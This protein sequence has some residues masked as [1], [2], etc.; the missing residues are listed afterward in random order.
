[1]LL[2][3]LAS[4]IRTSSGRLERNI[5]RFL[6][7]GVA[8][9]ALSTYSRGGFL[10]VAGLVLQ[11]VL[12]SRHRLRT[13][14]AATVVGLITLSVLPPEF[15]ERMST[16]QST[17][18]GEYLDESTAGRLHYWEVG[19]AM[20]NDRPLVGVGQNA[21]NAAYNSYDSS[22]GLYG[23]SRSVHSQWFGMLSELG[24]PGFVL[25]VG[26][27]AMA[28][29]NCRRV[30]VLSR[31]HPDLTT[32]AHY[33]SAIEGAL[34]VAAIGG[35]FYPFQYNEMLWHT[36]ALAMVVDRLARDR[37]AQLTTERVVAVPSRPLRPMAA[38]SRTS[39]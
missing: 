17:A 29:L 33:A 1:M 11:N 2:S 10:A 20:A 14:V 31:S 22:N 24:Y 34:I 36:I 32:L 6:A 3:L 15:W 25:F 37:V 26:I 9:R 27:L 7:I 13:L 30:R 21:Y 5:G 12:R 18:E 23:R 16:I 38:A 35:T 19:L 39:A 28:F 8:Y 4:L